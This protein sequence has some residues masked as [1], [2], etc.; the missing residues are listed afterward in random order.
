MIH[1][2][3]NEKILLTDSAG[4]EGY[5]VYYNGNHGDEKNDNFW[6]ILYLIRNTI[7]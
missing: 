3:K 2:E 6:G 1:C 5:D 7:W 4:G